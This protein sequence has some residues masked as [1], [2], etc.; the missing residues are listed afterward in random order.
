MVIIIDD[1]WYMI[2]KSDLRKAQKYPNTM[3]TETARRLH[4]PEAEVICEKVDELVQP[5]AE[6]HMN[7]HSIWRVDFEAVDWTWPAWIQVQVGEYVYRRR[8]MHRQTLVQLEESLID[9]P[10]RDEETAWFAPDG[11]LIDAS[12]SLF[13]REDGM[14]PAE[15]SF[16]HATTRRTTTPYSQ[17]E[18]EAKNWVTLAWDVPRTAQVG[19]PTS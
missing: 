19:M 17:L 15:L 18:R 16:R 10:G 14:F 2:P 5:M 3:K 8:I 7:P 13:H 11:R 6:R 4:V 1:E 12:I 9:M